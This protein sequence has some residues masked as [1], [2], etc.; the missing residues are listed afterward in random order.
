MKKIFNEICENL[1]LKEEQ[2]NSIKVFFDEN[3]SY[4]S[5]EINIKNFV[6]MYN[7]YSSI[8]SFQNYTKQ[9]FILLYGEIIQYVEEKIIEPAAKIHEKFIEIKYNYEFCKNN[10]ERIKNETYYS[11]IIKKE[12]LN[13]Y[14]I[15]REQQD[16]FFEDNYNY[17]IFYNSIHN[18]INNQIK[19]IE[20]KDVLEEY[21]KI[22]FT[23]NYFYKCLDELKIKL[24]IFYNS[25]MC[26][27][28]NKITTN[29][30]KFPNKYNLDFT[31]VVSAEI[32][33][34]KFNI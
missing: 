29:Y 4:I 9:N 21:K 2:I 19:N 28:L 33:R 6:K 12:R 23:N 30:F 5:S 15:L 14:N 11:D 32:D 13:E 27:K 24:P 16:M 8:Q 10:Y 7:L 34:I 3:K 18:N 22:Y 25:L 26:I 20:L 31:K 17:L 1:G